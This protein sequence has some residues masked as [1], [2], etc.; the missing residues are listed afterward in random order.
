MGFLQETASW[1]LMPRR[2]TFALSEDGTSWRELGA[3][4]SGVP[5]REARVVTRDLAVEAPPARA[6][7][8]RVR[9]EGSGPLPAWHP[10]AGEPS[11]FFADEIVIE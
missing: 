5:E 2:V 4:T 8:V 1:V 3:V 6:R 11:Y 7:F 9:I 10:G